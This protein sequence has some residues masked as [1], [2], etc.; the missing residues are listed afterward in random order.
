MARRE[1]SSNWSEPAEICRSRANSRK[2]NS[3]MPAMPVAPP[4]DSMARYSCAR[5]SPDQ[6]RPSKRS[7]SRRAR[8]ITLRL[9][10]MICHEVSDA[11]SS[12]PITICTGTLACT[13]NLNSDSGSFILCRLA[14]Y[15]FEQELRQAPRTHA[16]RIDARDPHAG[17]DQQG[18]RGASTLRT[19]VDTLRE[20]QRRRPLGVWLACDLELVIEARRGA[21]VHLHAHDHEQQS[22]ALRQLLLRVPV[23]AQPLGA[24]ALEVAQVVGVVDDG[25]AVGVFPVNACRPGENTHRS[26]SNSGNGVARSGGFR[27]KCRYEARVTM[28]PRAV[29]TRYPCCMRN[30]S[31]TSSSVP[32]SS[33]SAAAR[34]S[35]PTGPPSKRSMIA[36]RSL[37]SRVSNPS[38]STSRRSSAASATRSSMRPSARIWA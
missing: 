9:L 18:G 29:R 4:R 33:P 27:P 37:R 13:I 35:M 23:R 38:R 19:A 3:K 21:V 34:L 32:R 6:N 15:G 28:R 2:P 5:S 10:K 20:A 26:P 8:A 7:A 36:V 22:L 25:A 11:S 17:L 12:S 14:L 30:G 31:V 24:R 16:E 1:P